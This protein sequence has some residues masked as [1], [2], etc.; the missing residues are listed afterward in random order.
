MFAAHREKIERRSFIWPLVALL[1]LA[2]SLRPVYGQA[3]SG[4]II[5]TITDASGAVV[6]GATVTIR[7]VER[8]TE[9]KT[10]TNDSGNFTQTYLTAGVYVL[11]VEASGF[12]RLVQN[13]VVVSTD[14]A[15]RV[16]AQ[17]KVGAVTQE[18]TVTSTAPLLASDRAE[19]STSLDRT[20]VQNLPIL[21]RN[22]TRLQLLLPGAQFHTFQ[23]ASSENPQAGL[24]INNNGLDFGTS[25]FLIDG[26]DNNNAVLGIINVNPTQDS[27]QEFKH[28]TG[29]FDAEFAQAGGAVIQVTTRSGTNKFHG[30]LFEYLQN[31]IFNAR[32]SFSEPKGPPP[33]RVNQ[34]GGALG[35]P[36]RQNK[37]FFFG[38]YQG[39]RRRI[40]ASLLTT[41][42]TAATRAG[43]FSA[44]G[45]PIYDP[46]TG[47]PDGS[48]RTQFADP[49]RATAANPLGLNIIP[50]NRISTASA[51]LLALLPLPNSGAAG[52]FNNNFIAGGSEVFDSDQFNGRADHKLS[53]KLNY[54]V[55]YSFGG[56]RR[57]DPAAFGKQAG[58]PGLSG[59]FFSGQSKVRNQNAVGGATYIFNSTLATDFRVGYTRYRVDV[60]PGDF[61]STTGAD[62]G[63]PGVNL[64]NRPDT[65]GIPAFFIPGSGG[66]NIGYSL[67]INQCNCPLNERYFE[68]QFVDNLTKVSGNHTYKFGVDVRFAGN[69]RRPSDTKRNGIFNFNQQVTGALGV[70]GSGLAAASFLLGLPTSFSRFAQ[71]FPQAEDRQ[72]RMF[73]F[74]Q[75][76]W[77]ATNKLTL[78][79]GLRWDTWFPDHTLRDGE[80][81][82]YDVRTNTLLVA[83]VGDVN[84]SVNFKT[85]WRN[86][87]PRIGI[88]YQW[89]PKTVFRTGWGRSYFIEIFGFHFN[90]VANNFPN[91]ITQV[92]NPASLFTPVFSLTQ[93]PPAAVFP[94][95]PS[96]GRLALPV[97]LG[98][99]YLPESQRYAYV[100]SWNLSVERLLDAST[101]VTAT[102]VGNV[103]RNRKPGVLGPRGIALNQAVPGPGALNPRRPLF[104]LFG[105]TQSINDFSTAMRSNYHALQTKL[106]RRLSEGS[107]LLVTYTWSKSMDYQFGMGTWFDLGLNRSVADYDRTHVFTVGHVWELPFG[108]GRRYLAGAGRAVDYTLGGW[109]FSGIT[110]YESGW[111]FSPTLL[112]TSSINADVPYLRPDIVAS[113]DPYNVPGGQSRDRWFNV[114]AFQTPAAFKFGNAARNSL[115][116]PNFF[117]ADWS[118]QKRFAIT[119]NKRLSLKWDVFN[120]FNRTNLANPATAIDAGGNAAGRITGLIIGGTMRRMQI[121]LRFEF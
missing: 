71:Q 54:F 65:S 22:L 118:L 17:L 88:A 72:W 111:P 105:L 35:G 45:V 19:V 64:P 75:D 91:L 3:T 11:T 34:F 108:K 113:A 56:Y 10:Q 121:G 66:F 4:S 5:G 95:V 89:D 107:S 57:E 58:G 53:D 14:Q 102:Y 85:Q 49:T 15:T 12:V 117:T 103:G 25:N 74:A 80:G 73:Y 41:T 84:K 82:R 16:D 98:V 78:N 97:G 67:G 33:L 90:N 50:Q 69:L 28:A 43:D 51:K 101:T 18:M 9:T 24:Q 7:S 40:G 32:N 13:G 62:V 93:G 30:S 59:L 100:D 52:A 86:F 61:G 46:A 48:G 27:V 109:Q 96:N 29:N 38:D 87:S 77:R 20:Q 116:G 44:L 94:A 39:T 79:Y 42:P 21:D 23:H 92:V 55:R 104:N 81:S 36:I 70:A 76:T 8:G 119:E 47:A 6:A 99:N 106:T 68:Y 115:R 31:N 83:G 26:T 120:A 63:I 1:L 60:L 112:N 37:F 2:L 114:A 110:R